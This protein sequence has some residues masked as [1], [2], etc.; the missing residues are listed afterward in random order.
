MYN[1]NLSWK[2][3]DWKSAPLATN[4]DK[5]HKSMRT[6]VSASFVRDAWFF[7]VSRTRRFASGQ[8]GQPRRLSIEPGLLLVGLRVLPW[9]QANA[10]GLSTLR[11]LQ[12][13]KQNS[14]ARIRGA[15]RRLRCVWTC[16]WAVLG[17]A[18]AQ[19]EGASKGAQRQRGLWKT[20]EHAAERALFRGY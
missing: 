6:Q 3:F 18:E 5:I 7:H 20:A 12:T 13:G 4:E 9:G 16:H 2:S 15:R 14:P 8:N 1:R 19:R 10:D 17:S 11:P